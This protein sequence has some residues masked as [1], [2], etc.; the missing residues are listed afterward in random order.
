MD[1]Y[2]GLIVE[3][4]VVGGICF[5]DVIDVDVL[6]LAVRVYLFGFLC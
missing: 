5:E 4:G 6:F 3:V 2:D 1:K